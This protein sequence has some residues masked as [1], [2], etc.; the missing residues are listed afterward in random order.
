MAFLVSKKLGNS[1]ITLA[2]VK[3]LIPLNGALIC[4][5]QKE[6][7]VFGVS[8]TTAT[9]RMHFRASF[10]C[11]KCFTVIRIRKSG[12]I[13]G[14]GSYFHNALS[15]ILATSTGIPGLNPEVSKTNHRGNG[16]VPAK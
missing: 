11:G 2:P 7:T 3:C 16:I 9:E 8:L 4:L 14:H 6:V 1:G 12:P 10:P 5:L 15:K 13:F